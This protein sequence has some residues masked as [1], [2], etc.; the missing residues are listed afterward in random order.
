M[1]GSI[2][3]LRIFSGCL[4]ATSSISTPPSVEAMRVTRDV[5]PVDHR[6]EIE[7]AGDVAAVL[8]VDAPHLPALRARSG[9]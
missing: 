4:A 2:A 5:G 6:A 8:D 9:G 7:L 1:A 3:T